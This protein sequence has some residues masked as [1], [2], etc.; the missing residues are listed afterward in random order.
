[1]A[2]DDKPELQSYSQRLAFVKRRLGLA[3]HRALAQSTG[4]D[5]PVSM[6]VGNLSLQAS[7]DSP[8]RGGGR[9][10]PCTD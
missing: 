10:W 5:A 8:I 1:M 7:P 2:L 4:S 6:E 3:K 9:C